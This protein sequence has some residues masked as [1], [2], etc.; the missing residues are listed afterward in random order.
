MPIESVNPGLKLQ[1]RLNTI[2]TEIKAKRN[3]IISELITFRITKAKAKVKFG[4]RYLCGPKCEKSS[5]PINIDTKAKA[6]KYFG[7]I[8][9]TLISVSTVFQSRSNISTPLFLF[10]GPSWCTEEDANEKLN[11]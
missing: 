1:S 11:P 8:N 10:A 3:N 7:G 2:D 6:K 5:V 4:V 9:F